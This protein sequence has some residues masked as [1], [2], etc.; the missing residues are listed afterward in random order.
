MFAIK[1][2]ISEKLSRFWGNSPSH[3][4]SQHHDH[5]QLKSYSKGAKTVSSFTIIHQPATNNKTEDDS[6]PVRSS[7]GR[8]IS[9]S[10]TL[11]GVKLDDELEHNP[12]NEFKDSSTPR[13]EH[14]TPVSARSTFGSEIFEDAVEPESP[15]KLM[16]KLTT[17]SSFINVELYE[18]LQSSIPNIV[19]GCQW[20][21]LYSTLKHGISFRTLLRKSA[22][23]SGPGILIVGDKKGA[24]F[25]GLLDCPISPCL[26]KK[27]QGT[28]Q[29]FVFTTKYGEP[30]LFRATGANRYFYLCLTDLLAFGGGGNFALSL[31]EDLLTGRSGQCDT[32]GN[33]CLAFDPEFELKNVELWGFTHSSRY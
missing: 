31:D 26:K 21:L 18:F 10:C 30:R 13:N 7:L 12:K 29:T 33:S 2:K 24:V 14:E 25:G 9:N 20:V 11:R 5:P 17:D 23:M 19:K 16:P 22:D 8:W 1:S 4:A 6:K 32:F 28:N 3:A 27:Y 15:Q